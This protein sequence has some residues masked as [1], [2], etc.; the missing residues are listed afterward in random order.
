MWGSNSK[1]FHGGLDTMSINQIFASII[2][3]ILATYLLQRNRTAS[4]PLVDCASQEQAT[5]EQAWWIVVRTEQPKYEYFFGPFEQKQEALSLES[6]YV[7][8]LCEEG[9]TNVK[10]WIRWCQPT[11]ITSEVS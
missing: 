9:A 1:D 10:S 6:G 2:L 4:S 5:F 11:S 8:D 7:S 3:G